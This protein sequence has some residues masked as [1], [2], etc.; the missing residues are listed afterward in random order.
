M[1]ADGKSAVNVKRL[2]QPVHRDQH[3]VEIIN[4][5]TLN[6]PIDSA[7][8]ELK[9]SLVMRKPVLGVSNL[10][11]VVQSIVSLTTSLRRQFVKYMLTILS[12]PLLFFVGKM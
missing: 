5:G 2:K 4:C 7:C 12:N 11:P 3:Q 1:D 9:M 6:Y 8:H 10:G